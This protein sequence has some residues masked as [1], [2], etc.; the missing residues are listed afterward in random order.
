MTDINVDELG[1]VDYLV[2]GFRRPPRPAVP[3][4]AY[5]ADS[6]TAAIRSLAGDP[7]VIPE[8]AK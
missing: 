7:F 4:P 2:V 3:A 8:W 6:S 5:P 1:P